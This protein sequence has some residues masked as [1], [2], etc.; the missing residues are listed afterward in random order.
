[1][2]VPPYCCSRKGRVFRLLRSSELVGSDRI[3]FG[4]R[5][6]PIAATGTNCELE[7]SLELEAS[8]LLDKAAHGQAVPTPEATFETLWQ[9]LR[10][11]LD[12]QDG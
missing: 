6:Q 1:V 2:V 3:R 11:D 7:R 9:Q 10:Q 8:L 12:D 5:A 4:L